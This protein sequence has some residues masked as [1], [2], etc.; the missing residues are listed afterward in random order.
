MWN[1]Q[2]NHGKWRA[3]TEWTGTGGSL[4]I[5]PSNVAFLACGSHS[6]LLLK[7]SLIKVNTHV[8][9]KNANQYNDIF[10][11]LF[12][13]TVT[14]TQWINSRS[15]FT[16][17]PTTHIFTVIKTH[18]TINCNII[19]TRLCVTS[20]SISPLIFHIITQ[21]LRNYLLN[22]SKIHSIYIHTV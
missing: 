20:L 10:I 6:H 19:P 16:A 17:H 3:R 4:Y 12:H 1:N 14:S 18:M 7:Q 22:T 5:T 2:W 21:W 11:P 15:L 8:Y 13:F 9:R